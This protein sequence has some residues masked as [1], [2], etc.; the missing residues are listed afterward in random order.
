VEQTFKNKNEMGLPLTLLKNS[1]NLTLPNE[2]EKLKL[3]SE[4]RS[5]KKMLKWNLS[6]LYNIKG[7]K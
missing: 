1:N 2:M 7:I 5:E 6:H 4:M 3:S